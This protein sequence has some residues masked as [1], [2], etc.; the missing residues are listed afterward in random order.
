MYINNII[1]AGRA[2][3]PA[4]SGF[5]LELNFHPLADMGISD[6]Y[7]SLSADPPVKCMGL[8]VPIHIITGYIEAWI[9]LEF[10]CK[11]IARVEALILTS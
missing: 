9:D 10:Y 11:N 1:V 8:D 6:L 3:M 2:S 7:Y 5:E 4:I